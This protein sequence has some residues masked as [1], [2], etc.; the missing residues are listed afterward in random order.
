[1]FQKFLVQA[2]SGSIGMFEHTNTPIV[3]DNA[4]R[5]FDHVEEPVSQVIIFGIAGTTRQF[6]D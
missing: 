2:A 1:M 5:I 3:W 6:A 4:N